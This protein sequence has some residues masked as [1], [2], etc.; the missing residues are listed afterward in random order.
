MAAAC[1]VVRR[2]AVR[3]SMPRHESGSSPADVTSRQIDLLQPARFP[4]SI[5]AASIAYVLHVTPAI[6]RLELQLRHS[7]FTSPAA[8]TRTTQSASASFSSA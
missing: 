7:F 3:A 1:V 8:A 2:G 4:H 6:T 5:I